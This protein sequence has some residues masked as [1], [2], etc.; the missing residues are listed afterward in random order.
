[1]SSS[2]PI[3]VPLSRDST[4]QDVCALESLFLSPPSSCVEITPST[5]AERF[6]RDHAILGSGAASWLRFESDLFLCQGVPPRRESFERVWLIDADDTLW[7]DNLHFEE[8]IQ[9]L[10]L[11]AKSQGVPCSP[12]EL[13]ACIDAVEHEIIP[14]L[15]FGAEGFS[16]SLRE[17]WARIK[18][19][20][21]PLAKDPDTLFEKVIPYLRSVPF[22]ISDETLYFLS[23]L[24][25]NESHAIVLFTQGPLETQVQK[26]VNSTL[27]RLFDGIAVGRNKKTETYRALVESLHFKGKSY[28]VVG[29]SLNSEIR[30]ALELGYEAFHLLN[31][32]SWHSVNSVELPV[33]SY[34]Q[35][36]S[37]SEILPISS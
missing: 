14:K 22:A 26:I 36:T 13:R 8:L 10:I 7:E 27:A 16:V 33:Q 23:E 12:Q 31:P 4:M 37:L 9:E 2:D 6:N 3:H 17:S 18:S 28:A 35:V 25:K 34:K 15:G 29:N 30:P 19:L 21:A 20:H 24:R 11:H 1:M 32:N 5:L